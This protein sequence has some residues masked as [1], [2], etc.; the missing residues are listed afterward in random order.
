[1]PIQWHPMLARFLRH[2]YG[3]RLEIRSE[4]PLGEM[5]LRA[6]FLLIRRDPEVELPFPLSHLGQTTLMEFKGPDDT[7]SQLDLQLLG[8]YTTNRQNLVSP[9][10]FPEGRR[11]GSVLMPQVP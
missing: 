4:Y 8:I 10:R 6:D 9:R 7:A 11:P 1:M 5:P 2:D 3:D